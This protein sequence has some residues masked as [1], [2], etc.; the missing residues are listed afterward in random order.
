MVNVRQRF[1]SGPTPSGVSLLTGQ[2]TDGECETKIFQ[3][4]YTECFKFAKGEIQFM[5]ANQEPT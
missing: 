3:W 5:A 4:S 2:W 1:S